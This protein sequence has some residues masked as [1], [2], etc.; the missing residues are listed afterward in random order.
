MRSTSLVVLAA[1]AMLA[2]A[3][4]SNPEPEPTPAPVA[5]TPTAPATPPVTPQQGPTQAGPAAGSKADFA[6]KNTDRVY[7]DYDQFNLDDTDTRS[8]QGQVS[9]LK[10]YPNAKVQIEGHADERGTVD[11]NI[12]L[13]ARRATSVAEYLRAQGVGGDRV[14]T[15]S[16]G[17]ERP[18]DPGHDEAAWSRNRNAYTNVVTDNVG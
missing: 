4:A 9:W 11:Y 7:F 3:C 1:A 14:T 13:G 5:T 16:F 12:A 10:Q 2:T 17:K 15:I 8:L 6:A 18:L